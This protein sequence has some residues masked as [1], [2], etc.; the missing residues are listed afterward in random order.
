MLSEDDV[1]LIRDNV[2]FMK[3]LG[4][5]DFTS[6]LKVLDVVLEDNECLTIPLEV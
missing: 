3:N 2:R 6:E 5:G 1:K 4:F